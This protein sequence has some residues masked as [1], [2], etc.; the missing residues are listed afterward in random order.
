[1]FFFFK[2][3][4]RRRHNVETFHSRTHLSN[5]LQGVA[6]VPCLNFVDSDRGHQQPLVQK[7]T[8]QTWVDI[9]HL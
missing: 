8:T 3:D 4:V 7:K 6:I 5:R 9:A 1:M 2:I